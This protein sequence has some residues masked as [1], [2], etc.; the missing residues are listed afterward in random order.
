M[1]QRV[2]LCF[3]VS[4]LLPTKRPRAALVES[5][6]AMVVYRKLGKLR[7][8][9]SKS[10]PQTMTVAG[11]LILRPRSSARHRRIIAGFM[12]QPDTVSVALSSRDA[13]IRTALALLQ[14]FAA[15]SLAR[16]LSN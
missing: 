1:G 8:T 5:D 11:Y 7:L 4:C 9:P 14:V 13:C 2:R 12:Q 10:A 16:L 6:Q 3:R 15:P